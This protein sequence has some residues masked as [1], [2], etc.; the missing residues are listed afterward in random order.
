MS[1]EII[2]LQDFRDRQTLPSTPQHLVTFR[3]TGQDRIIQEIRANG[4]VI[5]SHRFKG[6]SL[7]K[8]QHQLIHA[9]NEARQWSDL[10][11]P[12][13]GKKSCGKW[14]DGL[15]LE[16]HGSGGK[17]YWVD[18]LTARGRHRLRAF[19]GGKLLYS[20]SYNVTS[21]GKVVGYVVV[22]PTE[23]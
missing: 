14:H 11:C 19:E 10:P 5:E 20:R 4:E 8:L 7:R 23:T 12:S 13:C 1:D 21:W 2:S 17:R 18:G 22:A 6:S 16:R 15:L 3:A 9:I